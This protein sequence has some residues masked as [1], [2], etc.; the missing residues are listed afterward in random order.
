[1]FVNAPVSDSNNWSIVGNNAS[2]INAFGARGD[3]AIYL[4]LLSNSPYNSTT[5]AAANAFLSSDGYLYRSTSSLKYK[6]NVRD[7]E[8]GLQ[9]L[10]K[11]RPV[12]YQSKSD[13]DGENLCGGLIA[14]EVDAIGLSEFV[15][16]A[17]DG[18]PD[19]LAYGNMITLCIKAIQEQQVMITELQSKVTALEAS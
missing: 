2:G 5:I 8:H 17:T 3:G 13:I 4:G 12:T 10:L 14:E 1:L 11:L 6:K 18:T 7:A 16:Y 15:Q 19:A 9:D